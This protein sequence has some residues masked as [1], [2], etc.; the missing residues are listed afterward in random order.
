CVPE[1]H[2][3]VT[4]IF[5]DGAAGAEHDLGHWSEESID[6]VGQSFGIVSE[7][8]RKRRKATDIAEHDG[9]S[10]F[11]AAKP[12][13]VRPLRQLLDQRGRQIA[14]ECRPYLAALVLGS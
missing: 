14:A 5:I 11:F 6:E 7:L 13:S 8:L 2:D 10:P 12:Q 3:A 4:D 9:H 1:R